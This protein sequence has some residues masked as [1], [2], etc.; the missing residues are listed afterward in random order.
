MSK[1]PLSIQRFGVLFLVWGGLC[2]AAQLDAQ[3]SESFRKLEPTATVTPF[4]SPR[5]RLTPILKQ[6][7]ADDWDSALENPALARFKSLHGSD[8]E[9]RWDRSSD[10]PHLIQGKGIPLIFADG[11]TSARQPGRGFDP[12]ERATRLGAMSLQDLET[13][14]RHFLGTVS[15]LLR[16]DPSTLML[17][18]QRSQSA[19]Q[20][21]QLW[22]L[23]FLQT[24]S[25]LPVAGARVFLRVSHGRVVQFG[26]E[27]IT[28]VNL[29]VE[30][31]VSREEALPRALAG[32]SLAADALSMTASAE[33]KILP[34]MDNVSPWTGD[35]ETIS[36][37][38][39]WEMTALRDLDGATFRLRLDA[40]SG[41]LLEVVDLRVFGEASARIHLPMAP[42]PI[43]APLPRLW[44]DHLGPRQTDE[45]GFFEYQG[46]EASAGLSGALIE[47][48]D[49]CGPSYL[50]TWDGDLD[51]GGT[52]GT[53]CSTPATGGAGNTQAARDAYYHL[54]HSIQ[55][56]LDR[57]S[58][59]VLPI[60]LVART[61]QPN[62]SC[63]AY[64]S[65]TLGIFAF[66][67]ASAECA[68]IGENPGILTHEVGHAADSLLGGT[69]SDGAS[70]EAQADIFAFL[71]TGD[72]C[73]G[74]GLRPGTPC[75]G[76]DDLCTG[77][78]DLGLFAA[79]GAAPL[80][81]PATLDA[82][83]G[84]S[85]DRF[86]CPYPGG[87]SFQ[88]PLGFQAHCE[89]Q[90]ASSAMLDLYRRLAA[91]RGEAGRETFE[92]LWFASLP[93]LGE[94]YRLVSPDQLCTADDQAV[95]GCGA[96]N[97]YSVL[98]ASDDDDG[99]L[100]NGTPNGCLIW[101]AFN[102]H[103]IACGASPACFCKGGGSLADAGPDVT[104]CRGEEATLGTFSNQA[105]TYLWQPGGERTPQIIVAPDLTTE[106]TL[107]AVDSCGE[108][109]DTV[110]V[111]VVAC[112][113][114]EEDFESGSDG[115]TTSGLWHAVTSTSCASP[116]AADGT[117]AMY[118][119]S[120]E[121]CGVE[122][123]SWSSGDMISPPIAIT[124]SQNTLSFDFYLGQAQPLPLGR[125]E[126]ATK[127]ESGDWVP[128]W[129]VEIND[130]D[131]DGWQTSPQ[132]SLTPDHGSTVQL[133]FRFETYSRD[134]KSEPYSGWLIDNVKILQGPNPG[135]GAAPTINLVEAPTQPLSK[136]ECVRC[137]FRAEDADGR[138]LSMLMTWS[139]DLDGVVGTG[140][141]SALI[142]SPGDH[143]LTGTVVDYDGRSSSLSV[144]IAIVEDS[145][146]CGLDDWPPAEPR[147]HCSDDDDA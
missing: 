8:W 24:H 133:R 52:N 17:D 32:L 97:W 35:R 85:C 20:Q 33:L 108:T 9:I 19:G 87:S 109:R 4:A 37:L 38:L 30:P 120:D 122:T 113:G 12:A 130:L 40:H 39:V 26:T 53:D 138:D 51:F 106:Y 41:E 10:R 16:V 99:N 131:I 21:R 5:L 44:V 137:R 127:T 61:N 72:T 111:N 7:R 83:D 102:D 88:G 64:W 77:I 128:R 141:P 59:D 22:H 62:M 93:G 50:S 66:G 96:N 65:E 100:A 132:I 76:C 27:N 145:V 60:T 31:W 18:H 134:R 81:S 126:V 121:T 23:E 1:T 89:S 75:Y 92:D 57:Y 46:G 70:G 14:A 80:A 68:N 118:Y 103:G 54:T 6:H 144:P 28:E 58:D 67:Q 63:A 143:V 90:I 73:I 42:Q 34:V 86:D 107:T 43:P 15:D 48:I 124:E 125:A 56:V 91:A 82:A 142:L 117:G 95:D 123:G 119:G 2:P 47:V 13:A 36:H 146:N 112:D 11:E 49:A 135:S 136:C 115:W 94:A 139:S 55:A 98:L 84:L 129:A 74:R 45:Y 114:F 71:Q 105:R 110:T 147:L 140:S 29:P 3:S 116:P 79:G 101:Q 25:G 104:I 69:A 78:R